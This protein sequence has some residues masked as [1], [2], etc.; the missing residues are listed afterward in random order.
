MKNQLT[1]IPETLLIPLW[2]R[3]YETELEES[4]IK[5]YLA[6]DMVSQI[7][8]D[9]NKFE[10]SRLSQLGVSVRTLVLD[11]ATHKYLRD[12][13]G[14]IVIN[15]GA[16]LDTR[17]ER[18]QYDDYKCWYDLDVPETIS[19]RKQ[20][21][22]E[23][24]QKKMISCSMFDDSW[25]D[26]VDYHDEP[27]LI[28][29]EGLLMYFEEQQI[30]ELLQKLMERFPQAELLIEM[31]AP[32]AVGKEKQHDSLKTMDAP[33]AFKWALKDTRELETWDNRI[34]YIQEWS[35]YNYCKKRWKFF[36]F[37]ARLP[38]LRPM[39]NCRIAHLKFSSHE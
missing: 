28:I 11:N 7:D 3:A 18:L 21:F 26:A 23:D 22:Q 31:L 32:I 15:L 9:F 20:F 37:I 2:A 4:I 10:K 38:I 36:G 5:D 19:L 12:K 8:Y 34:K 25:F 13:P 1:G 39:F 17:G 30:K 24:K 29:A 33:P 6:V 35:Y 27:V 14:A 16:G